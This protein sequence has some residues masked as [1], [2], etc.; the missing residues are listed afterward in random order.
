MRFFVSLMLF[1]WL[2]QLKQVNHTPQDSVNE[3]I[4]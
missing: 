4:I 2:L 3:L 1:A